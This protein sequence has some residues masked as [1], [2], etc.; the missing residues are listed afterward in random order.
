MKDNNIEWDIII[1]PKKTLFSLGILELYKYRDLVFLF[2]KRDFVTYYKQT[3]LGPIWYIIQP[4]IT[5][6]IITIILWLFLSCY[7]SFFNIL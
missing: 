1:T 7:K 4:L 3:I 5:T 2:F 6:V